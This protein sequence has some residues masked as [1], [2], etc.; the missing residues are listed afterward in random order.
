MQLATPKVA[1]G[2]F[3]AAPEHHLGVTRWEVAPRL[4][5]GA[6]TTKFASGVEAYPGKTFNELAADQLNNKI[7]PTGA[8]QLKSVRP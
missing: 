6:R 4:G 2:P 3:Y 1:S 8:E 5:L 7:P